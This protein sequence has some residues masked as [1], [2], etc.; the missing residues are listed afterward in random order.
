MSPGA[1]EPAL[2]TPEGR[3]LRPSVPGGG[4]PEHSFGCSRGGAQLLVPL[5]EPAHRLGTAEYFPDARV[6]RG[7]LRHRLRAPGHRA[8]LPVARAH[9]RRA[10][11]RRGSRSPRRACPTQTSSR[12]DGRATAVRG[13]VRR[14]RRL[15]RPRA[16]RR[17]RAASRELRDASAPAAVI[18]LT[19]PQHPSALERRGRLRP[20]TSRR[21]T[22]ASS[23]AKIRHAGF[24]IVRVTSFCAAVPAH[25]RLARL[26][27]ARAAT[28]R[29]RA[30]VPPSRRRS[31]GCSSAC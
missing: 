20:S 30:R 19:V 25:R 5:A 12:L 22:R 17:G 11:Q 14:R 9:G 24:D 6:P 1:A 10:L 23:S 27:S 7:R 28:V 2:R 8:A 3:S 29:P 18:V 31:T 26:W 16:H 13:R 4:F 15:R 21:Y